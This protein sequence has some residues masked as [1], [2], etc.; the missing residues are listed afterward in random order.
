MN[1]SFFL[2]P[3]GRQLD[4][5]KAEAAEKGDLGVV[6]E[7]SRTT[8][9]IMFAPPKLSAASVFGKLQAIGRMTGSSV[10]NGWV[11]R[12]GQGIEAREWAIRE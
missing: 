8:Q 9:G 6:A 4:Q 3:T 2:S 1:L 12:D 10:S 11:D 7:N 5:I